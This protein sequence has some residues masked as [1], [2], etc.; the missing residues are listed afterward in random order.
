MGDEEDEFVP[1]EDT[2]PSTSEGVEGGYEEPSPV[3]QE[4]EPAYLPPTPQDP[5]PPQ[6]QDIVVQ[7]NIIS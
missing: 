7:S 5:P 1:A 2:L 3:T 4:V 6:E